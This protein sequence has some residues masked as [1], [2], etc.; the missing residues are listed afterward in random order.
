[1]I[2]LSAFFVIGSTN[3]SGI[4]II[5]VLVPNGNMDRDGCEETFSSHIVTCGGSSRVGSNIPNWE[6]RLRQ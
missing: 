5:G 3:V 4:S 2:K 6:Q 1:M